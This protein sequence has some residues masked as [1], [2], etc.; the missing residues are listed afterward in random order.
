MVVRR[1]GA[2]AAVLSTAFGGEENMA[3][4]SAIRHWLAA[5]LVSSTAAACTDD[6]SNPEPLPI[7]GAVDAGTSSAGATLPGSGIGS[8]PRKDGGTNVSPATGTTGT[9]TTGTGTT[10]A[11]ID[12]GTPAVVGADATV[13][14]A[15]DAAV[16]TASGD[17]A[18]TAPAAGRLPPA[19]AVDKDGPFATTIEMNVGPNK[20]WVVRP[21]DLGKN[22]V[23]HPIFTWGCGGGSNP[24]AYRD[25]M[26]RIAS[27]GFIVESHVSTGEA[28]DH[29]AAIDWLIKQNETAGS[30][31]YQKL[32][33]AKIASGGHSMGSVAT[34]A[35]APDPR[36]TTTIHVSGG[37]FDGNGFM[38]LKKPA[39]YFCGADDNL[40]G[41]NCKRDYANT[42]NV[43]VF[44]TMIAG[45]D[46]I[47]AAR[48][49]LALQVA[50][51][52]WH[53]NDEPERKAEF[54]GT[55]CEFC[56][57]KFMSMSKNW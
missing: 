24:E 48:E 27:H 33:T 47:Y 42:T 19:E 10:G 50:W 53:L 1:P 9:G 20:G 43:P 8:V 40:A 34:F 29:K 39:A 2:H 41:D 32:N 36:L 23:L 4:T 56:K 13:P 21:T 16:G 22:G 44:L 49:S 14:S 31:Y 17:A 15:S 37:S 7:S 52:R 35:N 46:H 12:A 57:G 25:H 11:A 5:L 55:G 3:G 18:V 51:L 30:P 45:V 6:A 26:S 54:V 28:A 38:S